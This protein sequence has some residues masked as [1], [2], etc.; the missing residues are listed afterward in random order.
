PFRIVKI[1]LTVIGKS[2]FLQKLF[3]QSNQ[4]QPSHWL[5]SVQYSSVSKSSFCLTSSCHFNHLFNLCSPVKSFGSL[6]NI[7][8]QLIFNVTGLLTKFSSRPPLA[9]WLD[10]VFLI[11]SFIISKSLSSWRRLKIQPLV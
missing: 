10:E 1:G 2:I 5:L 7:S 3:S 11:F 8:Y 4:I 9:V 6:P